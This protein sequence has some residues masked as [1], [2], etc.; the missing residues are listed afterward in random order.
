MNVIARVFNTFKLFLLASF[1]I[2]EKSSSLNQSDLYFIF[3]I[4]FD[5]F[6]FLPYLF[7]DNFGK[8]VCCYLELF[9]Y[10]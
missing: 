7:L 3:F 1:D 6:F 10:L 4:Q 8:K 9:G 2:L 5:F